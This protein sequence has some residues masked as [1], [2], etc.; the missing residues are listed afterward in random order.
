MQ[1]IQFRWKRWAVVV[2]VVVAAYAVL[3]FWIVPLVVRNQLTRLAQ[4]QLQRQASVG[5]VEF[6]PFTLRVKAADLR[7]AE[8][9]GAPLF[10]VGELAAKLQWRSLVRW[11]WSF[12]DIRITAPN[13]NLRIAADGTFNVAQLLASLGRRPHQATAPARLPRLVVE[14]FMLERGRLELHDERAGYSNVLAPIDF[15]LADFSTLP[16]QDEA[17]VLSA[18]SAHG[19]TLRWK[20]TASV[21]PIRASGELSLENAPLRELG[22]Y[23]KP[24]TQATVAGGQLSAVLPYVFSYA[25]GQFEAKIGAAR[26]S[27]LDLALAREGSGDAFATLSRL[28]VGDVSADLARREALVGSL[29]AQGGKLTIRRDA[30][31]EIDLANLMRNAQDPPSEGPPAASGG[32]DWKVGVRQVSIEQMALSAVDET[33]DPPLRLQAGQ[34]RLQTQV[35]AGQS[36]GQFQLA[37]SDTALALADLVVSSGARTPLRLGQLGLAEGTLDLAAR[38]ASAGRIHAQAGR[39][40]LTRDGEGRLDLLEML[41]RFASDAAPSAA[42]PW[43]ASART[44]ELSRFSAEVADQPTG[45]KV[46]VNDLALQLDGAGSDTHRPVRFTGALALREGGQFSTQGSLLPASRALQA[47]VQVKQL[48]LAPLQPLLSQ[49]LKLR[50]AGGSASAQGQLSSGA[51]GARAPNWRYVGAFNVAG[52][53]LQEEDGQQFATWKNAVAD[54]LTLSLGPNRLDIP[55][56]RL[57]EPDAKLIIE[58]DRSFNAARLLVR[59]G[60]KATPRPAASGAPA[61][62]ETFAVRIRRLRLQNAKLDF[63]D[64]SLRPQ[65]GANIYELNGVVN[66]LS[67]SRNSRSQVQLDGRVNDYGLARIRGA[68]NPFVPSNNTDLSVVFRNVDMVSI[69]PYTMKFAGYRIAQGRMSLDLRY[70]VRN[71][72]LEGANRIIVDNLTLGER[73]ESPDALKLPLELAVAILKD[74]NGRID[75]GLPVSGNLNDPQFSYGAVIRKAIGVLLTRIVSAPFRALAGLFGA[76]GGGERLETVVFDAGSDRLLPPER[77]KLQQVAQLLGQRPQLK[78]LV[79]AQ[80]SESAD[81]AALRGR[82]VRIE[83]ARRAGLRLASGEDPG[84]VD[85]ADRNVRAALRSLYADRFGDAE[86]DKQRKAA[87]AAASAPA[88]SAPAPAATAPAAPGASAESPPAA[89]ATAGRAAAAPAGLPLWQRLGKLIQG[90]PQVADSTAFYNQLRQR[91]VQTQPLEPDALT[92][93]GAQRANAVV[94]AVREAGVDPARAV[95]GAP[96]NVASEPGRAVPLKLGLGTR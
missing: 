18:H 64:L 65:F 20:G 62:Q 3:G 87:E 88:A 53:V 95:A 83:V 58:N 77:E 67:S 56:L 1:P 72:Q 61:G 42:K 45:V 44:V 96:E 25:D 17:Y 69:S 71:G 40:Q 57:I 73:V 68:L 11:A 12:S 92:R 34:A 29:H 86:L 82:A 90:E 7:L 10:A 24:Y 60:A 47:D 14:R 30:N 33:V 66:E 13:A 31:G 91:L 74:S 80:Y 9:D 26:L 75:L 37:L 63:T 55:Q 50:I 39:L 48:A 85:L 70:T 28:E 54:Q 6:N 51:G 27:L 76:G 43:A 49:Y 5:R 2:L 94:A 32:K 4:S 23:L 38:R 78:L 59:G 79:P 41:P 35:A 93:L 89:G 46:H 16:Q 81:G 21:N 36:G 15:A 22:S 84:P 52:F 19:G 8:A